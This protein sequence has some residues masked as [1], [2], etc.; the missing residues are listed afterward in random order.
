MN[1]VL[2]DKWHNFSDAVDRLSEVLMEKSNPFYKDALIKRFE[3]SFE[4]AWKAMKKFLY[5][6]GYEC[7]SPR[8][9]LKKAFQTSYI[10]IL[11]NHASLLLL[12]LT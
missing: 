8:D 6:E 11:S 1:A 3:L 10:L 12:A 5:L 2:S 4:T 7:L 9:C